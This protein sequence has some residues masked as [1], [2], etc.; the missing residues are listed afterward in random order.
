M[1]IAHRSPF[2]THRGKRFRRFGL[3]ASS[4]AVGLLILQGV[5]SGTDDAPPPTAVA[6]VADP[7]LG[8]AEE[9]D[10]IVL[11]AIANPPTMKDE[12]LTTDPNRDPTT[13]R[14]IVRVK[15]QGENDNTA[16]RQVAQ[17]VA[18]AWTTYSY[19]LSAEEFVASLPNLAPG[20]DTAITNQIEETWT[21]IQKSKV[22]SQ[23]AL[24]GT[25]PVVQA[26]DS[27][28]GNATV[29]VIVEQTRAGD[30]APKSVRLIIQLNQFEV[31]RTVPD[32]SQSQSDPIVSETAW[33]VIGVRQQ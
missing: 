1:N 33:G 5:T 17:K 26:L 4:L 18:A 20:A 16:V 25:A 19:E 10:P 29:A 30:A 22:V 2:T 6:A 24:S 31:K 13:G 9:A 12:V 32:E 23:G 3:L 28:K 11:P 27:T 7:A 21:E 8:V 15:T 14:A